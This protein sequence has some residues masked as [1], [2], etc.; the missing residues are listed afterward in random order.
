MD[1]HRQK[2][3]HDPVTHFVGM[4]ICWSNRLMCLL[5][6]AMIPVVFVV[7]GSLR[8][9]HAIWQYAAFVLVMYVLV[10]GRNQSTYRSG[11]RTPPW[12]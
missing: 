12:L 8:W 1:F 2:T 6:V 7:P 4:L 10:F 9:A 5:A 11:K 3:T